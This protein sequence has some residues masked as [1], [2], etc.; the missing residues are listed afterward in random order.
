MELKADFVDEDY[1]LGERLD[2]HVASEDKK[3]ISG[4]K[5]Q[6]EDLTIQLPNDGV[7]CCGQHNDVMWS[8]R[9]IRQK[10]PGENFC[11]R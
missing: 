1:H 4:S 2:F 8:Y 3:R 7:D 6:K 11:I 10:S 5:L 9:G